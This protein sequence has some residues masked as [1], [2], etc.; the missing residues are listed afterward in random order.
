M[1]D[2]C[3]YWI[4]ISSGDFGHRP[5]TYLRCNSQNFF[6]F[7]KL[8]TFVCMNVWC[9][10]SIKEFGHRHKKKQTI[11]RMVTPPVR[12]FHLG[13]ASQPIF[14]FIVA[15][16]PLF[17]LLTWFVFNA[18]EQLQT[19]CYDE[20]EFYDEQ[21]FAAYEDECSKFIP[22]KQFVYIFIFSLSKDSEN[23]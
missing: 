21:S 7:L 13:S 15:T 22:I 6:Q 5:S 23:V 10:V 16:V 9:I 8:W 11:K 3:I 14:Q 17:F 12:R 19:S 2:S 18:H 20:K 1:L 4:E